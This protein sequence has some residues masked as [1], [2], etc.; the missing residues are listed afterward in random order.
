ML[1]DL[2]TADIRATEPRLRHRAV[3]RCRAATVVSRRV[4]GVSRNRSDFR[5]E[6][7]SSSARIEVDEGVLTVS[8]EHEEA[9]EHYVRRERR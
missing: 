7:P 3:C 1:I 9:D 4:A 8:G 2:S 6:D 5:G